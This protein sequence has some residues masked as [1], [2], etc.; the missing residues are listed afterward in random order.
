MNIRIKIFLI[1]SAVLFCSIMLYVWAYSKIDYQRM[2]T[3]FAKRAEQIEHTFK[4]EQDSTEMRMLQIATYVAHDQKVQQLFLLGKHAVELEGGGAGGE[5]ADQVRKSLFEHVQ[6]SQKSLAKQFGFRQLHFHFDPGSHSFLRVHRPEKFGDRM[7]NVRYTIVAA[8]AKQKSTMGFETGRVVSGIR[9]VTPVYAF[10]GSTGEKV[11]VGALEAGTSFS[12]MLSIFQQN[13]PWLNATVLL[14]QEHLQA[15]IWPDFLNQLLEDNQVI[16]G[17]RIEGTT[18]TEIENFLVHNDF[19]NVLTDPGHHLLRAG[20]NT[21]SFASFPLR[22]YR[23]ETDSSL[24]DAGLVVVWGDISSD[25]AAYHNNVQNLF[26]YGILLF[27]VIELLIF[28]GLK[29][30][31]RRLRVEL[32]QTRELE[33]ASEHARAVAEE[34]S[35][36]KTEFLGNMSH[37]LRTPMNTIIG[38]GQLLGESPLNHQQQSFINKI[39]FSSKSLLILI[40]EIL[41]IADLESWEIDKSSVENFKPTQLLN[42]LKENFSD[43]AKNQGVELRTEFTTPVPKQVCGF[44]AQLE[45]VLSQLLGNA[46]KF[47]SG[48]DVTLSLMLLEHNTETVTLEFAVSD[49][50]IGISKQQQELIFNPFQQGDGSKTRTY[51]GTGLGLTIARK[52]CQQMGGD[53]AVESTLGQG[54]RFSFNLQLERS[55]ELSTDSLASSPVVLETTVAPDSSTMQILGTFGE[56]AQLLDQL[57]EPLAQLQPTECQAI[58]L[59]IKHKQWPESLERDIKKLTNLIDQYRFVEAQEVVVNLN[60]LL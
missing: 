2:M 22:D 4:A 11:H 43:R 28:F 3:G 20:E 33:I 38:L 24:P 27:A 54:S 6:Q 49:Q 34:A 1:L 52:V 10:D 58:G 23:G 48:G 16:N 7:D 40:D 25:I 51:G 5:L 32:K 29:S 36:L 56:I 14:S 18:S 50:G 15:N 42:Q 44:P 35:R 59:A 53:I 9:G 60:K 57:K 26:F 17:F 46:I 21:Y 37:E 12:N 41:L 19:A 31:T 13:R 45:Q 55:E 39:N 47:S 30:M 8:N